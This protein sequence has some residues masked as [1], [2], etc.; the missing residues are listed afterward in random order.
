MSISPKNS[1][2]GFT[3]V[4][5]LVVIAIIGILV[6]LL[7]PAVQAARE[8]ARRATC[9]NNIR[10]VMLAATN[11]QSAQQRF[12]GGASSSVGQTVGSNIFGASLF[13]DLLP[14]L[15]QTAL[16]ENIKTEFAGGG[17]PLLPDA[18]PSPADI[19]QSMLICASASQTD[20]GDDLTGGE[21]SSHYVGISGP[22]VADVDGGG[23]DVRVVGTDANTPLADPIGLD[24]VFSPFSNDR[25]VRMRNPAVGALCSAYVA[26]SNA[27]G[28][29]F[30]GYKNNKSVT[31]SD[32]GDG[33]SN[34]F[35][36]AEFSGGEDKVNNYTPLRGSW[37]VGAMG[38]LGQNASGAPNGFFVPTQTYQVKT[39][40]FA[41][42]SKNP[43]H[44][45]N[46]INSAPINSSHPGGV[47][48]ARADGSV[49]YV[50]DDIELNSLLF[51]CGVD[52][53]QV[54]NDF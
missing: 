2:R 13:V 54:I 16:F 33:S 19:Q 52:D 50:A 14:Y 15:E 8:A 45:N 25:V 53:G 5:L 3:L 21:F 29:S 11:Y 17:S 28:T 10:Q 27:P 44:Y 26:G 51:L 43:A 31:F 36:F 18:T 32:I 35:A 34:T 30:R 37:A 49:S 40:T 20:G 46:F 48:M 39:V 1:Q 4:E 24:G 7:L 41:L 6:G 38:F 23:I 9:Q 22:G 47:N 12:P 42:N